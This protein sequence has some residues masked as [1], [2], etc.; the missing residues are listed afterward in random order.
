I[1]ALLQHNAVVYIATR[2][3]DKSMAV[4]EELKTLAGKEA[5]LLQLDLSDLKSI[6]E[7]ARVFTE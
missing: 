5:K 4:I 1:Q 7:S 6:K 3:Q 2:N